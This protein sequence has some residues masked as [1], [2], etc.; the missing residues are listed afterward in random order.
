MSEH[1]KIK[2]SHLSRIAMSHQLLVA[3]VRV[4]VDVALVM[5]EDQHRPVLG[6]A[7]GGSHGTLA[8]ILDAHAGLA[9]TVRVSST[10]G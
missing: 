4:P 3:T 1:V 5:I 8:S 7:T 2:P 6:L 10:F 9:S